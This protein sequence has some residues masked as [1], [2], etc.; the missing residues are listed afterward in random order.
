MTEAS[1][2]ELRARLQAA[3]G[4]E[5]AVLDRLGAGGF[6]VVY[7]VRD[8]R[9]KRDLALKVLS[10]DLVSSGSILQRFRREA[11]TI[12]Q[13]SHP[14]IVPLHFVGERNGL[15]YLVMEAIGGGS[16]AGRLAREGRLP[17]A[18]A[19]RMFGEVAAALAYAHKHGV[20]HRDIKPQNVLLD[21]ESG[22]ALVTD[23]GIA[24]TAEGAALTSTGVVVGTPTYLS[25]EQV[26]GDPC[27]HRVDIYALGVMMYEVLAGE[28]PFTAATPQAMLLKRLSGSPLPLKQVRPD[29]PELLDRLIQQCLIAQP[30]QRLGDAGAIVRAMAGNSPLTGTPTVAPG[31]ATPVA[32]RPYLALLP[33]GALALIAAAAVTLFRSGR[34]SNAPAPM[35][36]VDS[37]MVQLPSGSF[38]IGSNSGP[39]ASRPAH[40]VTLGSFGIDRHE[41]TIGE[42]SGFVATGR[43]PRTWEGTPDTE[44]PVT[45][46]VL[47]EAAGYCAWKHPT[48]GRLPTEAEWEVAARGSSGRSYPWGDSWDQAAANVEAPQGGPVAVGRY[49]RG[50]SP[51]GLDD[52]IGNV[53]EWTSSPYRPYGDSA[54]GG[55]ETLYVIRGGAF[56]SYRA[57]ATGYFR[58]R[59]QS[60]APRRALA[61]TGFRCAMPARPSPTVKAVRSPP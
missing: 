31:S 26:G 46:V 49:P 53:W 57:V 3:L 6:A 8:L 47:A 24:R 33:L 11:E 9:L 27:D 25:P 41:V 50:R 37:G 16:L 23:F 34:S 1:L 39:E 44:L 28:P 19:T 59:V 14:N 51:E 13:L 21:A 35:A 52:L 54:S 32:R 18:D 42:Y 20:I 60:A 40:T 45:G 38:V 30:A 17:V 12:A 58:G 43:A 5:Y 48:G 2:D 4:D 36:P 56:N 7:R 29:V 55:S 61:A 15:F 10:P 22:R